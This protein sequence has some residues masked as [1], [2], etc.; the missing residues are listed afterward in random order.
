M[1]LIQTFSY[2]NFRNLFAGSMISELGSFITDTALMLFLFALT[3][4]SKSWLGISQTTFILS[5]TLGTIIGGGLRNFA[6]FKKIL[7]FSNLIRMPLLVAMMYINSPAFLVLIAGFIAFFQGLFT[8]LMRA[9][10]NIFVPK[11]KIQ[12]ANS[13]YSTSWAFLHLICPYIGAYL[14][15]ELKEIKPILLLDLSTYI[16][17]F[18]FIFFINDLKNFSKTTKVQKT[19]AIDLNFF[20]KYPR[21]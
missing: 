7:L 14:F 6:S 10:T 19:F 8:P 12:T 18:V 4:D 13:I 11:E 9:L 21:V 15:T 3:N 17:S 5:Y 2:K 20:Q 1:G 16:I